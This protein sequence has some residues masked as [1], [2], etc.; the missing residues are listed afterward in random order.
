MLELMYVNRL[1]GLTIKSKTIL[2][3]ANRGIGRI[4]TVIFIERPQLL[5]ITTVGFNKANARM[6]P[7]ANLH[8]KEK[9]RAF[10]EGGTHRHAVMAQSAIYSCVYTKQ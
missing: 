5:H 7:P 6:N 10:G 2:N 1:N 3:H 8:R 4:C 9:H